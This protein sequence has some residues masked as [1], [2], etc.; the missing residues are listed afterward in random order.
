[1]AATSGGLALMR[2]G[3]LFEIK[4]GDRQAIVTEQG[5]TLHRVI[6]AGRDILNFSSED[7]Y[8]AAG[9]HGQML[10]P[11]PGRIRNGTYEFEG[12]R[13]QVPVNDYKFGSAIHGWMRWLSWQ[14]SE[15]MRDRVTLQCR[16]LALPAYPFP[17]ELHQSYGW[18]DDGLEVLTTVKN[19]GARTAPFGLGFHPY[20]MAGPSPIDDY[21]LNVPAG[22][23]FAANEDL[24]PVLPALPV[25]GTAFDFRQPR[26]VG[27]TPLDVTL[28]DL[29]RD[30]DGRAVVKLGAHDGSISITCSYDEPINY[31]QLYTGD[32]LASQRREGVAI[33]PYTC[34]PDAFNNGLGLIRLA[35]GASLNVRWTINAA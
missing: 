11:W 6:W 21:V 27:A 4:S 18:R 10:A 3:E 19:L 17:L 26:A 15:Q 31:V 22:S 34:I 29:G 1:M 28:G 32:T 5:A 2:A 20:F 33:E 30:D 14:I 35:P 12:D 9:S 16:A 23:Y 24:S 8:S 13:F 7:G 25:E